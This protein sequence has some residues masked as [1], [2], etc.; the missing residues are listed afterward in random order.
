VGYIFPASR[1]LIR[2][3]RTI[4]CLGALT[5]TGTTAQSIPTYGDGWDGPGLGSSALT[6]VWSKMTAQLPSASAQAEILRAMAEWS[7]AVRVTWTQGTNPTG[8]RTVNILWATYDHGDGFPFTGPGGVLAHTFYPAPPNPEPIA[9]DMHLNDSET[10]KIGSDLDVFSVTLHEL[11]HALGL[12]HS[13][14]PGAVMYP[15][16]KMAAQLSALD[17]STIQTMYAAQ[18][19]QLP[20]PVTTPAPTAPALPAYVPL[21]LAANAPPATTTAPSIALSGSATGGSGPIVV[22]WTVSTGSS[23]SAQ[24]PSSAWTVASVSLASGANTITVTATDTKTHV[25]QSFVVTRQAATTPASTTPPSLTIASPSSSSIST[26][27]SSLVFS[28]TASDNVGV[29]SVT[30]S[31]NT[32]GAGN[33]S[34]TTQWSATV[35]LL[36][37]SNT[38]LIRATDAAGKIS[39]RTAVVTRN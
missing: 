30:W 14:D 7:K 1:E 18:D 9:G 20:A 37:G 35:P 10:W 28:G 25:A 29:T 2:G 38:V 6:Y 31:T 23:G 24:G 13:D 34:G 33:A 39:W 26:S 22:T 5:T 17:I 21:T 36:V 27:A 15:Y 3:V 12:G 19:A 8:D 11:G 16:Y 32:G 4:A